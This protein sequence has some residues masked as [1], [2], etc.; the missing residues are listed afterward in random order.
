MSTN[1]HCGEAASQSQNPEKQDVEKW[2]FLLFQN[3]IAFLLGYQEAS[4]W[5]KLPTSEVQ[6]DVR[7]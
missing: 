7:M 4:G 6:C 3:Y 2:S 1:L 5:L